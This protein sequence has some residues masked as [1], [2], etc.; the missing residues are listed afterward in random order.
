V[1][2]GFNPVIELVK[3]PLAGPLLVLLSE[4]VGF[5]LVPQQTPLDVTV[6]PP[7]EVTFPPLV[8]EL[9][10]MF[11][12]VERLTVGATLMASFLQ[13]VKRANRIIDK[14]AM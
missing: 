14:K 13:V 5:W 10:V 4:I 12:T 11:D 6:E 3:L 2:P 9:E 8:A 1:V 7:S